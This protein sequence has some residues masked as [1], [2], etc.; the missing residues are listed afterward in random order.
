[1]AILLVYCVANAQQFG[2]SNSYPIVGKPCPDFILHNIKYFGKAQASLKDFRGKWLVLDFFTSGCEGCIS[3]FPAVSKDARRFADKLTYMMVG[4]PDN[5][6][7]PLYE[8]FRQKLNMPMPCA[9]DRT[10]FVK[11]E[12]AGVPRV[13]LIDD[14]GIVRSISSGLSTNQLNGFLNGEIT[15]RNLNY[16]NPDSILLYGSLITKFQPNK[17]KFTD[18]VK[19]DQLAGGTTLLK[20]KGHSIQDL[21]N[22]AY[23][24]VFSPGGENG[25]IVTKLLYA[26][27][28]VIETRDSALFQ[29]SYKENKNIFDYSLRMKASENSEVSISYMKSMIREQLS[30]YFGWNIH[31]ENR[32][33]NSW[34]L[35]SLNDAWSKLKS[36][37]G[38]QSQ[39][40][41]VATMNIQLK[42]DPFTHL[43]RLICSSLPN[44]LIA[45]NTGIHGNVDVNVNG[46]P[47]TSVEDARKS[48]N[49]I[50]LD[51]VPATVI[52]KTLVVKDKTAPDYAL[53]GNDDMHR[54]LQFELSLAEAQ[55]KAKKE[56]KLVFVYCYKPSAWNAELLD[57]QV[58]SSELLG[59]YMKDKMVAV[60]VG[61]DSINTINEKL[62]HSGYIDIYPTYVFF[63]AE[64]NPLHLSTKPVRDVHGLIDLAAEASDTA[65]QYFTQLNKYNRGY[66]DSTLLYNLAQQALDNQ[67]PVGKDI[68]NDYLHLFILPAPK[69]IRWGSANMHLLLSQLHVNIDTTILRLIYNNREEIDAINHDSQF[70]E[71]QIIY[72]VIYNHTIRLES[73]REKGV[74]PDWAQIE[75]I[76]RNDYPG[77]SY[78]QQLLKKQMDWY[79][80]H[81]DWRQYEY[82]ALIRIAHDKKQMTWEQINEI[83]YVLFMHS[84]NPNTLK[85]AISWMKEALEKSNNSPYALDTYAQLLYKTKSKE[86][87]LMMEQ[88]VS[89]ALPNDKDVQTNYEKMQQGKATWV[90]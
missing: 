28:P 4:S 75:S 89:E 22:Y 71:N 63:S 73:N 65:K 9:F 64:G 12:V 48:L 61:T 5:Y 56:N 44:E 53:N 70:A 51:L 32:K 62:R 1:M 17:E 47:W 67:Q 45:D 57:Q 7:L 34:R 41:M 36:K 86:D 85:D 27:K 84:N 33:Y 25:D 87:Y 31:V 83:A 74:S 2:S 30:Q 78:Q 80:K 66:R 10:L 26:N 8:S 15:Q 38:V 88:K 6:I 69:A 58:F 11:W 16:E 59:D 55:E 23:W 90:Q 50:G 24:G 37:G 29:Y 18:P 76:F 39:S 19:I 13:F 20:C 68:F 21:L 42:N 40:G 82:Y 79:E 35:I 46:G 77:V 81:N 52:L 49:A 54:S 60:K 72:W 43:F 3:S 14:K